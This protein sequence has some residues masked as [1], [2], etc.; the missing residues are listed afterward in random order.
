MLSFWGSV[1][2]FFLSYPRKIPKFE[3]ETL[4]HPAYFWDNWTMGTIFEPFSA[5]ECPEGKKYDCSS[6][7]AS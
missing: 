3:K 5:F 1:S 7:S 6:C 4:E 2:I